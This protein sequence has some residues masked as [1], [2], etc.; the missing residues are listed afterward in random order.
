MNIF[1]LDEDPRIAAQMMCDKHV[2][3][4]IVEGC[5]MLS[6]N[7]RLSGSPT[8]YTIPMNLYKQAFANHPCTVW[9]R[10]TKENYMWLAD[11]TL[12]LC[13][14]YTRRYNRVHSCEEMAKWFSMYYPLKTPD[15]DL[16][17]FAQAMPDK[18]KAEYAIKAY[19]NYYIGEKA[20]FA[21]W[22]EKNIPEW[23]S[24]GLT[25]NVSLV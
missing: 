10:Q 20:R 18:Y 17:P 6:T 3:K 21:R 2:V 7:H 14:E 4:M 15:G 1:I 23:Y 5:Q 8:V 12:E 16:T 11:H 19:R 25:S 22:K 9:A 24:E 13:Q